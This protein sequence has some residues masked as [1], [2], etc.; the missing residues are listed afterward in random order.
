M[1]F[2]F[3]PFLNPFHNPQGFGGG[4]PGAGFP[5]GG[6]PNGG[7]PNGGFT[8]GGFPNGGFPNAGFPSGA[9]FDPND[10]TARVQVLAMAAAVRAQIDL[11][12]AYGEML[13]AQKKQV[14][15]GITSL[16]DVLKRWE[17]R[18]GT[19]PTGNPQSSRP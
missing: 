14:E 17:E 19:D 8:N 11:L 3:P 5:N 15:T 18:A 2:S 7:F 10:Q 4:F 6:F 16:E 9:G 12:R 13:D 1:F